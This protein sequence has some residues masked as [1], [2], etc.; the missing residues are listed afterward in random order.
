MNILIFE[1]PTRNRGD[2]SAHRGLVHKLIS[3]YPEARIVVL[4]YGNEQSEVED[5]RVVADNVFYINIP[6][7]CR[8]FSPARLY[9]LCMM[10]RMPRLL[11]WVPASRKYLKFIREADL[12][13][14]APG[15]I[16]MGGFMG[17]SHLA[18]LWLVKMEKK[19]LA[20]Y[21]RSIG[22]FGTGS[23]FTKLF[24]KYSLELL[25]YFSF[26]SLRDAKSQQTALGLGV[27][28]VETIDSAFLRD[29]TE[30]APASFMEELGKSG[31]F[32]FVPN[33]LAWHPAYKENYS[34]EDFKNVWVTLADALLKAYPDYKMV[35]L[36]QTT[37]ISWIP[38]GY[39]YFVEI[40]K[41]CCDP[42]RIVV[43]EEQY[44]SDIQQ[45]IISRSRFLVGAR[46]HSVIFSINQNVPFVSLSY[47]HKMS[48]VLQ[49]LG[50]EDCEVSVERFF[51]GKTMSE[52]GLSAFVK[53]VLDK[54]FT[55]RPDEPAKMKA[56]RIAQEGFVKFQ[57][58]VKGIL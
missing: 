51:K 57:K 39:N 34:Y 52:V 24:R 25:N 14:G 3:A 29:E 27:N 26:V 17:W 22:P 46:Y 15:G 1:Q 5:L 50:K 2:E 7:R 9:K 58:T 8:T 6:L 44:G 53:A 54:T 13:V 40:R 33:S 12:I 38:D 21:G 37:F 30:A 49:L 35:M 43:L 23:Y 4:F 10:L 31:Y 45:G 32:V 47:E 20:Y 18:L 28:Y 48:G 16:E 11:Y 36:P 56:A 55:I 41:S 42:E 19:P